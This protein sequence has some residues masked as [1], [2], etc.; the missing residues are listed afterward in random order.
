M[1]CRVGYTCP[2]TEIF[3]RPDLM[4]LNLSVEYFWL[5][6]LNPGGERG[7]RHESYHLVRSTGLVPPLG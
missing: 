3:G 4:G 6:H 2:V 7:D 5:A 1:L